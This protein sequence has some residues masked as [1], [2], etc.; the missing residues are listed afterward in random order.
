MLNYVGE[1]ES[2]YPVAV[3]VAEQRGLAFETI[4]AADHGRAFWDREAVVPRVS[5]FVER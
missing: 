5:R 3:A 4:E 2:W 1:K